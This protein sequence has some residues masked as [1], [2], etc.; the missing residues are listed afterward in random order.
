MIFFKREGFSIFY[1]NILYIQA[2][3]WKI[4]AS[5]VDIILKRCGGTVCYNQLPAS[6]DAPIFPLL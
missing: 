5:Y 1:L 4:S 2:S 6:W 3:N